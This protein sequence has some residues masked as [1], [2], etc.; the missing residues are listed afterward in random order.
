MEFK[1][2]YLSEVFKEINNISDKTVDSAINIILKTIKK[3][4]IYIC[5][6]GG[7]YALA[8]HALCDL[9]KCV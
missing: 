5:G 8:N 6:N 4:K 2:F 1:S 9:I 7:S 3:N